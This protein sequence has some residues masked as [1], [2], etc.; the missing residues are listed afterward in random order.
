MASGDAQRVWFPEMLN[1]RRTAWLA[2]MTW[3]ELAAICQRVIVERRVPRASRSIEPHTTRCSR[4]GAVSKV[5]FVDSAR[6]ACHT[7]TPAVGRTMPFDGHPH[8]SQGHCA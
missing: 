2:S 8:L 5:T 7:I 1:Q 4:C 6:T 3:D